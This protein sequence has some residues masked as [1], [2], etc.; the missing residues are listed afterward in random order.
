MRRNIGGKRKYY[1]ANLSESFSH[2]FQVVNP[3]PSLRELSV[4]KSYKP[5]GHHGSF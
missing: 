5:V 3:E 2:N 4:I 1:Q